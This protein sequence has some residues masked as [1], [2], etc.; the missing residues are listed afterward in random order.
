MD[1]PEPRTTSFPEEADGPIISG[2]VPCRDEA[3][4]IETVAESLLKQIEPAGGFEL[5]FA[6]GRSQDGTREILE[7]LSRNDARIRWV[8]NPAQITPAGMNAGIRAA[9]GKYIAILGAHNRYASNYLQEAVRILEEKPDIDNVGGSMFLECESDVQRAIAAVFHHPFAVGGA[10]WHN[11]E[12]EGPADTVFGGVYRRE[13]FDRIGFFDEE[14]VR[15]QDD[16][17]NLR[18]I[19]NGG[20]IWHTPAMQSWYYPRKTIGAVFRMY[21]QYGYWKVRVIQKHRLPASVRHLIPGGFVAAQVMLAALTL[22]G[23]AWMMTGGSGWLSAGAMGLLLVLW[24]VYFSCIGLCT[25]VLAH[26]GTQPKARTVFSAFLAFHYGYGIGFVEGI[27][28]FVI[29]RNT[30]GT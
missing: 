12:Y 14:L 21:R 29:R 19:R 3:A 30:P 9:R 15:N 5:I 25:A 11:P 1:T 23:I 20:R 24:T 26:S 8:D 4:C 10:R 28:D 7:R 17:L 13:V 27:V 18:L 22:A 2:I 16:E 6:D